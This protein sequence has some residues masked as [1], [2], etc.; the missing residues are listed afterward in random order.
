MKG[1]EEPGATH[2]RTLRFQR[3]AMLKMMMALPIAGLMPIS[4]LAEVLRGNCGS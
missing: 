1:M 2:T 3:R 4:A